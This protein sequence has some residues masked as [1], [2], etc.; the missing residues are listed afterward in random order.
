MRDANRKF[1]LILKIINVK[2]K[3]M[4][5][6]FKQLINPLIQL[7]KFPGYI[8]ATIFY[9]LY[10]GMNKNEIL[11]LVMKTKEWQ[12]PQFTE[13]EERF[14]RK[15]SAWSKHLNWWF[16]ILIIFIIIK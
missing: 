3:I 1:V 14:L 16:W 11:R 10:S 7:I 13:E 4:Y 5:N 2:L 6:K 15:W 9:F 12:N 8:L